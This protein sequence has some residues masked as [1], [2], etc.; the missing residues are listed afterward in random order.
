M[1]VAT[2][3]IMVVGHEPY[4]SALISTLIAGTEELSITLEKGGLCKHE[5]RS[6]DRRA[7]QWRIDKRREVDT[8]Y[9][10]REPG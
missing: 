7:G 8:Q 6:E 4:L 10:Q 5:A 1:P 3:F 9:A 2:D